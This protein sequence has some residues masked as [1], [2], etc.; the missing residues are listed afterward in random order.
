MY[1]DSVDIELLK[2]IEET[3]YNVVKSDTIT[4]LEVDI[5]SLHY[6]T[7]RESFLSTI[8]TPTAVNE[9][10]ATRTLV[11][12]ADIQDPDQLAAQ[13]TLSATELS[14]SNEDNWMFHKIC[15]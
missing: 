2:Q 7:D 3:V 5:A 10:A 14:I 15:K 1:Q 12:F 9:I 13:F 4:N 11:T 8:T 6:L